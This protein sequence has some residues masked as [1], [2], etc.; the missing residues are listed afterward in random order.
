MTPVDAH[1]VV[2]HRV[3]DLVDDGGP[4]GLNSQSLLNLETHSS[5]GK[6]N[7]Y[8]RKQILQDGVDRQIPMKMESSV[9]RRCC[10]K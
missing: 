5:P 1:P 3:L 7:R 2:D 4:S 6:L 10:L 8:V 9:P